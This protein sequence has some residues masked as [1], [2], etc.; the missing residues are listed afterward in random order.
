MLKTALQV[1]IISAVCYIACSTETS[2][3]SKPGPRPVT[4]NYS[5]PVRPKQGDPSTSGGTATVRKEY[6][7]EADNPKTKDNERNNQPLGHLGTVTLRVHDV[8]SGNSYPVDADVESSGDGYELRRLYFVKGGWVDFISCDLD[9]E[10][11][12]FCDDEG[13]RSWD[14]QGEQ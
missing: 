7:P 3:V 4:A 12:G 8:R 1:V 5:G 6:T 14:I 11:I 10:Y 13:G 2:T 9:D